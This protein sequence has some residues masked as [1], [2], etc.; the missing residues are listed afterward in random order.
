MDFTIP[1]EYK[2]MQQMARRFMEDEIYPLEKEIDET[3]RVP[4]DE[5]RRLVAQAVELGL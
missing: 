5:W 4:M 2:M 1:D 3:D